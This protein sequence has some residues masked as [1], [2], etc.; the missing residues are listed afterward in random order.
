MG[1]FSGL[2]GPYVIPD[3][4]WLEI[5]DETSKAVKTIPSTFVGVIPDIVYS[6]DVFTADIWAFW[7]MY[8]APIVLRGRFQD[9]KY[10]THLCDFIDIMKVTL[11][12]ETTRVEL[13]ELREKIVLWVL[14]YEEYYYQ[15]EDSRLA[16]CRLVVHGLLHVVDDIL[17]VGPSWATWTFFI[18]RFC[19]S[20]R[21]ALHSRTKPWSNLDK[22]VTNLAHSAQLRAKYELEDELAPPVRSGTTSAPT[23]QEQVY[24]GYPLSYLRKPCLTKYEP[25]DDIRRRVAH[26]LVGLVGGKQAAIAKALPQCMPAWGKVRIGGGGDVVR[27][28]IASRVRLGTAERDSSYV[29]YEVLQPDRH[30]GD[31]RKVHYGQLQ[32]VLECPLD[33]LQKIWADLGG[34]TLLLALITPCKTN[35]KDATR[36]LTL[37]DGY[38]AQVVVDLRSIQAVVGRVASRGRFGIVDRSGTYARTTFTPDEETREGDEASEVELQSD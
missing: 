23:S 5:A 11:R 33:P 4:I 30:G 37:C 31:I 13:E 34:N 20:L 3:H 14:R 24:P 26:Y 25:G 27:A 29:R 17:Y 19:G 18:E 7:F 38:R 8:V 22:R 32:A 16:A 28:M 36:E 9:D 15:Y 6:R 35:D 1:R 2:D 21:S 10:Y 12:F